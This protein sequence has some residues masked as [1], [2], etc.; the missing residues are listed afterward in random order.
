MR[1]LRVPGV[2][3]PCRDSELLAAAVRAEVRASDRVLDLFTGSGIQ[4][5][6][7]AAAGAQ[8]VTAIDLGRR[9]VAAVRLNAMINGVGVE[10]RR[11]GIFGPVSGRRFDLIVGNPPYVPSVA[12]DLPSGPARA[13]EGGPDGRRLLDAM[14]SGLADH[15]APGGR[16]LIVHS[17]LCDEARTLE[18]LRDAGMDA[19]VIAAETAPLGPITAPRAEALERRGVLAPGQRT[20]RTVVIRGVAAVPDARPGSR[21]VAELVTA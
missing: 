18:L 16:A 8:R 6:T 19:A 20:E 12:D 14:I 5:I 9:A 10:V 11:G 15:L 13:W 1:L 21:P 2:Y 17:S 4:A 3:G 7:A